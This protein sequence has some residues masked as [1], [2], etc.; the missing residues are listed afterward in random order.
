M[1]VGEFFFE[2]VRVVV[3]VVFEFVKIVVV[4]CGGKVKVLKG[5]G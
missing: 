2:E 3:V 4:F 5:K 1:Y